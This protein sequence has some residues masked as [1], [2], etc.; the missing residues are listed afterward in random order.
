M[1]HNLVKV[2]GQ[3][4]SKEG[5]VNLNLADLVLIL[6]ASADGEVLAYDSASAEWVGTQP[7]ATRSPSASVLV[8]RGESVPYS[9][10]GQIFSRKSDLSAYMTQRL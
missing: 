7:V 2:D 4:P 3:V 6:G 1:S 5:Q 9:T 10:N 8:G